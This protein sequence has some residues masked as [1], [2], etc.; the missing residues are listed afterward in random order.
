MNSDALTGIA[1]AQESYEIRMPQPQAAPP[2][3]VDNR[4]YQE[5]L[6]AAKG[7]FVI[8]HFLIGTQSVT[9]L[10]GYLMNV[11]SSYFVLRD[12]CT[13]V[14]TTCDIYSLKFVSVYPEGQPDP[15]SYCVSR[16]HRPVM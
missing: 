1:P 14:E 5:R 10:S 2:A 9:T 4:S 6:C 7:R 12:P 3:S 15:Q 8:C 13:G 16:L 11:G